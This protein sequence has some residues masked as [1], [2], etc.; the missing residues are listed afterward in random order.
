MEL[1]EYIYSIGG[2]GGVFGAMVFLVYRQTIRQMREDRKY[3]EDRMADMVKEDQQ[4]RRDDQQTRKEHTEALTQLITW[5]RTK[6][7][8]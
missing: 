7:G 3:M 2:V 5:L 8:N 1:I 4:I 6:N